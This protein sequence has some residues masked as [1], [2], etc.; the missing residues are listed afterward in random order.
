MSRRNNNSRRGN[1]NNKRLNFIVAILAFILVFIVAKNMLF[2]GNKNKVGNSGNGNNGKQTVVDNT[3]PVL[4]LDS[5]KTI[6]AVGQSYQIK[7]TANDDVDGDISSKITASNIDTSKEG[8]YEVTLSVV[9]NAGNKS[10]ATQKVIVREELSDGLPV[11]MYHFFYD[12]DKYKKKDSNWLN[13]KDFEAQLSYM[14]END[15]YF[16]TWNEVND[17]VEGK[18]KLPSKSVVLTVDD[19][20]ESFFELAVPVMQKYKVP[21]TSFVV[22]EWYGWRYDA[23]LQYVVW[24]SHSYAMHE[25]GANGKGRMVNWSYDQIVED[26]NT[27]SQLLGNANVFCYPFGHYNDTAIKALKDTNYLM[28]FTVEGG[29]VKPNANKYTLPRVRVADGNSLEHFKK[30]IN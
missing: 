7:A 15:F 5:E 30:S 25:S 18:I 3:A 27:S 9:D 12:N 22:A 6:I 10:E 23:N 26:L 17:Y 8:E 21:A 19:G 16:P 13:I 24:E 28:A 20:D 4:N 14:T 2:K 29:R 11:L 1:P